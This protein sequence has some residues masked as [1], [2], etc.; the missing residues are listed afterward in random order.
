[1]ESEELAKIIQLIHVIEDVAAKNAVE[2][3]K[4]R[5]KLREHTEPLCKRSQGIPEAAYSI[6]KVT[7]AC[8]GAICSLNHID[9]V[10]EPVIKRLTQEEEE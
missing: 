5:T 10:V 8:S 4:L 7:A 2:L 6:W 1:M 3:E 9:T